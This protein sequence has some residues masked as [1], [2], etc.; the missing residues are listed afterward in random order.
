MKIDKYKVIDNTVIYV[1]RFLILVAIVAYPISY[2]PHYEKKV[3]EQQEVLTPERMEEIQ[4]QEVALYGEGWTTNFTGYPVEGIHTALTSYEQFENAKD[5]GYCLEVDVKQL[6]PTGVYQLVYEFPQKSYGGGGTGMW[7]VSST[8]SSMP[9]S[10]EDYVTSYFKTVLNRNKGIYGQYYALTL[11]DGNKVLIL[12]ND[13][14]I[15]L[16]MGG[17][18]KLPY[19]EKGWIQ[20]K[21][22]NNYYNRWIG[23]YRLNYDRD[24]GWI[25]MLDASRGWFLVNDEIE[26]AHEKRDELCLIL[27]IIGIGGAIVVFFGSAIV[28]MGIESKRL[29][30]ERK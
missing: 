11:E 18:V 1:T 23:K 17:K 12:L 28:L 14:V 24:G 30:K 29:K 21:E 4:Q 10:A 13:T 8:T 5:E 16:P 27:L 9:A 2:W 25:A 20:L 7:R 15:D 26:N 22:V 6:E 19:A 3:Y